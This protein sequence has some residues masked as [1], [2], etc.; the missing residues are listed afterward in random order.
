MVH[1]TN[2][3]EAVPGHREQEVVGAAAV[4]LQ[5]REAGEAAAEAVLKAV[6][7]EDQEAVLEVE[8]VEAEA[9]LRVEEVLGSRVET[10]RNQDRVF[11]NKADRYQLRLNELKIMT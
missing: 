4:V 2:R 5:V 11:P 7:V 1:Q 8:A 10:P 6:K 9:V 3:A